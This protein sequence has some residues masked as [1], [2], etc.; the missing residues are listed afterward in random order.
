MQHCRVAGIDDNLPVVEAQAAVA[1]A[2]A[3]LVR[4][5]YAYDGSKL[6]LTRS[7]GIVESQDRTYLGTK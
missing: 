5:L 3:Q 6:E 1:G 7:T 2:Q 4:A